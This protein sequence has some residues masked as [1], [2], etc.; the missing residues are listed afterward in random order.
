M[1]AAHNERLT[2]LVVKSLEHGNPLHRLEDLLDWGKTF[3]R[4]VWP[5]ARSPIPPERQSCR[6]PG[7]DRE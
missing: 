3:S 5:R 7:S 1:T 4:H 6:N 2:E